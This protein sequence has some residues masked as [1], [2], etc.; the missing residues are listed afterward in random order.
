MNDPTKPKA[1]IWDISEDMAALES[2][3]WES[4][5]D[6]STPEAAAA[7]AA[8]ESELEANLHG[9][10]DAYGRLIAEIEA[11]S[12]ARLAE[13]KRLAALAKVDATA[14]DNLRER[15][16][17]VFEAR[18]LKKVDT[19]TFRFA[20]A[21][22]GGK[23]AVDIHGDVA[24]LPAWAVKRETLVYPDKDSIRARLEAGEALDFARL[25]ERTNRI[26]IK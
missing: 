15:L 14:A 5:G 18:G 4:G 23:Q 17:F 20:L 26:S 9:K 21:A 22:N 12:A 16:R 24:D 25:M 3:L 2:L 6:I 10:L 11:R 1:T 19:T 8:W 13:S 7:V